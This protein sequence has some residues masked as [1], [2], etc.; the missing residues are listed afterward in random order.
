[1]ANKRYLVGARNEHGKTPANKQTAISSI[2]QYKE[3]LLEW[4]KE[5]KNKELERKHVKRRV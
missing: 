5:P 2:V 4:Q 3:A 1:V